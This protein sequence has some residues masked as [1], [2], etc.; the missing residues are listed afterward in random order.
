MPDAV[1][2][3]FDHIGRNFSRSRLLLCAL[4][5]L[6]HGFHRGRVVS[7]AD[8]RKQNLPTR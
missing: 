4:I 5:H 3:S 1:A 8:Y 7:F 6:G 2:G